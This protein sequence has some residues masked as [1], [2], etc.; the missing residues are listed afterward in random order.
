[1][2]DVTLCRILPSWVESDPMR[3]RALDALGLQA[4]AD[5]IADVLLPGLSVLT[6]RARY[7][8]LL[9]WARRACGKQT[10]EARIHRLEVALAT[11]E[12][13]LHPKEPVSDDGAQWRCRFVGSRNLPR[14]P[15]ATPYD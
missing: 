10:D 3:G 15:Q 7:Y 14:A 1:M 8:S 2:A 9:V 13:M 4:S 6:T 11:R 5:R 12:A